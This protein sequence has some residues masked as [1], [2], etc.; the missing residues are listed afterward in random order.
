MGHK[1]K[2]GI[3]I[4]LAYLLLMVC[5]MSAACYGQTF[6]P[7]AQKITRVDKAL[8]TGIVAYR[9]ADYFTTE[10][11]LDNGAH[12]VIMPNFVVKDKPLFAAYCGLAAFGEIM[13]SKHLHERGHAKMARIVNTL[14]I[15]GGI[16]AVGGNIRN[17]TR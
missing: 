9:A 2:I 1:I 17:A 11:A 3:I 4:S 6:V 10:R 15:G 7:T 13:L 14:S 5:G 12:E 8:Y 16:I